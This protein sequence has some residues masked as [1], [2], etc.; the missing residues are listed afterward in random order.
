MHPASIL[1]TQLLSGKTISDN[2][3][4][5]NT[6][7]GFEA[8]HQSYS[9]EV[10]QGTEGQSIGQREPGG[11]AGLQAGVL[12]YER[13]TGGSLPVGRRGEAEPSSDQKQGG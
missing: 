12:L 8:Q 6:T 2:V 10:A 1:L 5:L 13:Q 7:G 9:E 11:V 4:D 3:H